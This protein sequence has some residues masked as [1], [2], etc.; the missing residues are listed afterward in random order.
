MLF[1]QSTFPFQGCLSIMRH[2]GTRAF[3]GTYSTVSSGV[4]DWVHRQFSQSLFKDLL[5]M[6][7][8]K[9]GEAEFMSSFSGQPHNSITMC[10]E[11]EDGKRLSP[12][13]QKYLL[14]DLL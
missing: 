10:R 8:L 14:N 5:L 13:Y 11:M 4:T 1:N 6:L 7:L 12:F 2:T 9:H 3:P